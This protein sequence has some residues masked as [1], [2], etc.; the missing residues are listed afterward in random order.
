MVISEQDYQKTRDE[1]ILAAI[2]SNVDRALC[3]DTELKHWKAA[4]L[5]YPSLITGILRTT[6][7]DIVH[8]RLG[9]LFQEDLGAVEDNLRHIMES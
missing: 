1:L 5:L 4:G 7:K 3:G 8:R 2:S 6:K 9:R